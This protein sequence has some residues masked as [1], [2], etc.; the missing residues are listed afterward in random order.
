MGPW[1]GRFNVQCEMSYDIIFRLMKG[2]S[3][4]AIPLAEDVPEVSN[5]SMPFGRDIL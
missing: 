2:R 4:V 1:K 5:S 3:S